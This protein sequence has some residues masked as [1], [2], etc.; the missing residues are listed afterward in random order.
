MAENIKMTRISDLGEVLQS[1]QM[2]GIIQSQIA[3]ANGSYNPLGESS[4]MTMNVHSNPYGIPPPSNDG[5]PLPA[6]RPPSQNHSQEY[7]LPPSMPSQPNNMPPQMQQQPMQQYPIS[8]DQLALA[9]QQMLPSRD[10]PQDSIR[11]IQDEEIRPNY[12]P[13][14]KRSDDFVR[15]YESK[16]DHKLKEYEKEKK[17]ESQA[18][19]MFDKYRAPVIAAILFFIL[20][21][22]IVNT[23]LF[24]PFSFLTIYNDDGNF[25]FYGLILK[26]AIFGCIYWFIETALD[27]LGEI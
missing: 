8:P 20:H 23:A 27:Y 10:I 26:S 11:H 12:I 7:P 13:K 1:V 19:K 6:S 5:L 4:Y 15:E 9:Q 18:D 2:G 25:N 16:M 21:M 24:K 3:P 22:P 14:P 17:Q